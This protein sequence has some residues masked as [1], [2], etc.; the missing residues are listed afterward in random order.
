MLHARSAPQHYIMFLILLI[1]FLMGTNVDLFVPSLPIIT[2]YYHST[3]YLA[4]F[5]ISSYLL[6]YGVG[7]S[8][9][10]VLSDY[11]GRRK[12]LLAC[13]MCYVVISLIG[14]LS[15]TIVILIIVRFMQGLTLGGLSV[16]I[17]AVAIDVFQ[18][19]RLTKAM[20]NISIS[21]SLGPIIGPVIGSYLQHYYGW[22]ADFLFFSIYGVFILLII[23]FFLPET[24][25]K[26]SPVSVDIVF[27]NFKKILNHRTFMGAAIVGALV[28]SILVLFN[29]VAPFLIENVLKYSVITY[30]RIAL[31]MGGSYCAGN[32]LN[33]LLINFFRPMR[34]SL[35]S[36]LMALILCAGMILSSCIFPMNLLILI[37]PIV[38]LFVLC[39]LVMP[40]ML[41]KFS[42][43]FTDISGTANAIAG[44]L[45]SLIV[46]VMGIVAA[47][48]KTNSS[49]P[50][51]AMYLGLILM[52][53]FL[54]ASTRMLKKQTCSA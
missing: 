24:M 36:L 51:V 26:K 8:F 18:G 7:Q 54:V 9:F 28:Y 33:R 46:G 43:L 5:T 27:N 38:V 35:F 30:G 12:I 42:S 31:L 17:R 13:A 45:V 37:L 49:L 47:Q 14:T 19:I 22:Q 20:N 39:G 4:Q 3:I 44:L 29:L 50:L 25:Q 53:L 34:I 10:G 21:W 23:Q 32:L 41:G 6:A 16:V 15:P 52:S 11:L 1:P 2:D 40:N 48:F